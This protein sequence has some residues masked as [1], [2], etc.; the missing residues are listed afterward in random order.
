M[1]E[2]L[3]IYNFID[4]NYL[5]ILFLYID[6]QNLNKLVIDKHRVISGRIE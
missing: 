2:F 5:S 6:H 4:K 1:Y 3:Y